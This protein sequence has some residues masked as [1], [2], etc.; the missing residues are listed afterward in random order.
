MMRDSREPLEDQARESSLVER[1]KT[2]T[3]K[4]PRTKKKPLIDTNDEQ[5]RVKSMKN[6][7]MPAEEQAR[8][9]IQARGKK[10]GDRSAM[11]GSADRKSIKHE[12]DTK[13]SEMDNKKRTKGKTRTPQNREQPQLDQESS[14]GNSK[15]WTTLF[16]KNKRFSEPKAK[17]VISSPKKDQWNDF[18]VKKEAKSTPSKSSP[19]TQEQRAS[20][21]AMLSDLSDL[22][23]PST[24][25]YAVAD[26]PVQERDEQLVTQALSPSDAMQ[27]LPCEETVAA[28]P[29]KN[30]GT[31][32]GSEAMSN[33]EN[34]STE[35]LG[36]VRWSTLSESDREPQ[37]THSLLELET[38][39]TISFATEDP[40]FRC[41]SNFDSG[42]NWFFEST[43]SVLRCL[44]VQGRV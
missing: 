4:R 25:K 29:K 44:G 35:K 10:A 13:S 17:Y 12:Q 26:S 36:T 24:D 2:K 21:L 31:S 5:R 22:I 30:T 1:T 32:S 19:T 28:S 15:A 40:D 7:S 38:L 33:R 39:G 9:S 41:F 42:I 43:N 37:M 14:S 27:D 23:N 20:I 3:G 6:A 16:K 8:K 34:T 11:P 18:V